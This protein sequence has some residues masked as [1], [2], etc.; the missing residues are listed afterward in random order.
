MSL[1]FHL[2]GLLGSKVAAFAAGALLVGG[3]IAVAV[4]GTTVLETRPAAVSEADAP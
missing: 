1:Q 3:G 2:K 4:P